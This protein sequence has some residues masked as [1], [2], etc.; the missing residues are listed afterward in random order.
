M[1]NFIFSKMLKRI[2]NQELDP[3]K[4]NPADIICVSQ[5]H[6][7]SKI[8]RAVEFVRNGEK[9]LVRARREILLCAGAIG[10]PQIL[11][12]S[13]IGPKAHLQDLGVSYVCIY[14][15]KLI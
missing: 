12:L 10:S 14:M 11:M 7:H 4:F 2:I 8:A 6:V 1:L 13:G 3:E 9:Q 5:I 15:N